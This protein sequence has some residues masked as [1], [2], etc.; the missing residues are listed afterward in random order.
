MVDRHASVCFS[1]D[2]LLVMLLSMFHFPFDFVD[3]FLHQSPV[4][5]ECVCCFY[6]TTI[7][8]HTVLGGAGCSLF[9]TTPK[10]ITYRSSVRSRYSLTASWFRVPCPRHLPNSR[11]PRVLFPRT[12]SCRPIRIAYLCPC[13]LEYDVAFGKRP[14]KDTDPQLRPTSRAASTP[15]ASLDIDGVFQLHALHLAHRV[16]SL[17]QLWRA[18]S[19]A[20][21]A[22]QKGQR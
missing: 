21:R 1:R 17:P 8:V 18:V 4:Q 22:G 10:I 5:T 15:F 9:I 6:R 16:K 12:C 3:F 2:L 20:F 14:L 11:D 19:K 7:V 13:S